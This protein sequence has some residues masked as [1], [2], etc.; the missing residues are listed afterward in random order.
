MGAQDGTTEQRIF[1]LPG[2]GMAAVLLV[3][4]AVGAILLA[5]FA[6]LGGAAPGAGIGA[7]IALLVL[8][9][10]GAR[11]LIVLQPNQARVATFFG[12]Y[13]GTLRRPGLSWINPL[14]ARRTVSL[15][16][17]TLDSDVLKV[18]DAAGNPVEIAAVI[19]WQVED[20]GR[21]VFDVDA[22]ESF[23]RVQTET[24]IRHVASAYPYDNYEADEPSL[25]ANADQVMATLQKELQERLE[26]AGVRV[27]AARIRRLNYAPEI[28]GEMLRRQQANAVVAARQRI[29][30]GA[31]GMVEDALRKLNE[32]EL[33]QLDEE[34]KAAMVSNLM[35]VLSGDRGVQ[36]V[37][38]TGTLYA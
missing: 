4:A 2:W 9:A 32:S 17:R 34:R 18:N 36:P 28:A 11:G 30:L 7:G 20:T 26:V 14:T 23:V 19:N 24:A 35:V 16:V 38:N 6:A 29:V 5:V 8:A 33:V 25:R 27:L 37:V 21:A 15:R 1:T 31:V 22:Y 12:S 13:A 3:V 10:I